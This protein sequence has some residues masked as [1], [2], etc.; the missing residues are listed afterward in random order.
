LWNINSSSESFPFY[1]DF[2]R[3]ISETNYRNFGHLQRFANTS[4]FDNVDLLMIAR[5]MKEDFPI[6]GEYF[7][8]VITERGMCQS[9]SKLY[10]YQN[11]FFEDP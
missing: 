6:A 11:P 7:R 2:V 9:S 10:R 8:H 5:R 1:F 4:V 3:T